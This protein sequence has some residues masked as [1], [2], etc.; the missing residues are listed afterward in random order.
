MEYF[1]YSC[2]TDEA[3]DNSSM[4][5]DDS[6]APIYNAEDYSAHLSKYSKVSG[7]QL[8]QDTL[9][10]PKTRPDKSRH[11]G[12][13][14]RRRNGSVDPFTDTFSEMGLR[15][16]S[17]VSQLLHKLRTDLHLS[18][19][20]FLKEFVAEPN[21]GVTLLLD[22]LKVIQLSEITMDCNSAGLLTLFFCIDNF[23]LPTLFSV[24]AWLL[25][26]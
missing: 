11:Y 4:H 16:F 9:T 7:T 3:L 6:R 1:N 15:Q 2:H 14:S 18:Y 21:D 23:S 25:E 17:T 5:F 8:Y 12:R 10:P 19:Y 26:C 20:S 24:T 13:H 22:L